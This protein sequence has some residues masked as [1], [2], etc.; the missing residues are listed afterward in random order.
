MLTLLISFFFAITIPPNLIGMQESS[1]KS[2]LIQKAIS[3]NK[4]LLI[5][6]TIVHTHAIRSADSFIKQHFLDKL[7]DF[8][9]EHPTDIFKPMNAFV[10]MN[11]KNRKDYDKTAQML[12]GLAKHFYQCFS[13]FSF[14]KKPALNHFLIT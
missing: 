12:K 3:H 10:G 1:T 7:V 2:P 4:P 14:Q 13:M 9:A 8:S 6:S 5:Q 11:L